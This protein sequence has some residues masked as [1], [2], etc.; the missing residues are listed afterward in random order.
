MTENGPRVKL[1]QRIASL[2]TKMQVVVY[3]GGLACSFLVGVAVLISAGTRTASVVR[4]AI[5]GAAVG[6]VI[7][8]ALHLILF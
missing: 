6:I 4:P 2:E 7:R 1:E 3:V 8:G 5:A